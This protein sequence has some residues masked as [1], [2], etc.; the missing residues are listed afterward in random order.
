MFV[1][2]VWAAV[3][4]AQGRTSSLALFH[5]PGTYK[6]SKEL[7]SIGTLLDKCSEYF[8]RFLS[9]TGALQ[10]PGQRAPRD[11]TR[12]LRP[13]GIRGPLDYRSQLTHRNFRVSMDMVLFWRT[14][15]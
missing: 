12:A 9:F 15:I 14:I 13:A 10:N 6:A 1:G 4:T 8:I 7:L 3:P 5:V 2:H 11:Q